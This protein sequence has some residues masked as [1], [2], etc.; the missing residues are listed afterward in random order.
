M[1]LGE[2][3]CHFILIL[4]YLISKNCLLTQEQSWTFF[5]DLQLQ[6]EAKV[7]QQLQQKHINHFP[8]NPYPITNI[9]DTVSYV[10]MGTVSAMMT[11]GA[12]PSFFPILTPVPTQLQVSPVADQSSIKLEAMATAITSL[13]EMFK[14]VL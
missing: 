9:Y 1:E 12:G 13:M 11:Q 8:D 3:Y 10:L 4:W 7:R 2:Y 6:L 5:R 14:N